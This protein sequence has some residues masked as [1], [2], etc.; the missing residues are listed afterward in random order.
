MRLGRAVEFLVY[1]AIVG[2]LVSVVWIFFVQSCDVFD[3]N[4]CISACDYLNL[5]DRVYSAKYKLDASWWNVYYGYAVLYSSCGG[6]IGF[7]YGL[8]SKGDGEDTDGWVV[9]LITLGACALTILLFALCSA[10]T[11]SALQSCI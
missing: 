8:L 9:G 2:L 11:P 10:C 1:G 4:Y 7:I 6:V 5:L 3:C